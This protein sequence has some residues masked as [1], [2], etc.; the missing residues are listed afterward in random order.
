MDGVASS[1]GSAQPAVPE[2]PAVP[3]QPAAPAQPAKQR[4]TTT[5]S[6]AEME[7]LL[8]ELDDLLLLEGAEPYR[9]HW[10]QLKAG[11]AQLTAARQ[12]FVDNAHVTRLTQ[13][14]EALVDNQK[15]PATPAA[16]FSYAAALKAGLPAWSGPPPVRE[17]PK[18]LAREL[19]IACPDASPQD[20]GR[21][22]AQI[23]EEI[24]KLKGSAVPGRVLAA[25]RLPSGD[26]LITADTAETK[27]Q[28]ES[29]SSW[30]PAVGQTAKVNRRRFTVL[31]HG[32]RTSAL[33]CSKPEE[34][35][36]E[37]L[38]QNQHLRNR[39]EILH[40][41]WPRKAVKLD[42][43]VSHLVVDVASP[44]QA[45]LL[46]D[47]GL[48][49]HSELKDCELYHGDCRL[50]QC[51]NCQ[52]YGHTARV[53]RSTQKCGACAALGHGDHDCA[54]RGNPSALRCANCGLGH[55]AWS[56]KCRIRREQVEKAQLAYSTRPRRFLLSTGSSQSA[57]SRS[58]PLVGLHSRPSS[59]SVFNFR[60]PSLSQESQGSQD[61][62]RSSQESGAAGLG[63]PWEIVKRRKLGKRTHSDVVSSVNGTPASSQVPRGPGR[64]PIR[65]QPTAG[66]QDIAEFF[67]QEEE[68]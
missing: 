6:P 33:D 19:V 67:T 8:R 64:P 46:I 58:S 48:L 45:N 30:L 7:Q 52:K 9:N 29:S 11:V 34:A 66:D 61:T 62:Q 21:P 55:P 60:T 53:C 56:S 37:L 14:V 2:Q 27:E 22:I 68:L 23:V 39:V 25:R 13:A 36:K 63:Q 10:S 16:P 54:L 35:I 3:A 57:S 20:R 28:L 38:G 18:R 12:G 50:T 17:V 49:F 40:V 41:R 44:A 59:S 26:I 1:Q 42:K 47:E 43:P 32:M 5:P 51:F 15:K 31:V 65:P 4:T 24:N